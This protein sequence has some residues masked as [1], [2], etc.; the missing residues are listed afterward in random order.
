MQI[1]A[2]VKYYFTPVRMIVTKKAKGKGGEGG[3]FAH[4]CEM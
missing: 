4:C 2:I 1:K 3:T